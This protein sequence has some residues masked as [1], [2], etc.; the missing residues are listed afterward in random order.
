VFSKTK[1]LW[2]IAIFIQSLHR[3]GCGAQTLWRR[4][5]SGPIRWT[6]HNLL[7]NEDLKE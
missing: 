3:Q 7:P 6:P 2:S 1:A 4:E 5:E